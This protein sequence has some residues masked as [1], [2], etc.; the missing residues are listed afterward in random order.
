MNFRPLLVDIVKTSLS[1]MFEY[2]EKKLNTRDILMPKFAMN[3]Q[4]EVIVRLTVNTDG[5][6]VCKTPTTSAW[7]L[8][9]AIADLPPKPR[10]LFKNLVLG[11]LFVGSGYPDFDVFLSIYKTSCLFR[12]SSLS[13]KKN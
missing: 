6:A 13:M 11:A 2:A 1:E 12:R 10:Q 3:D 7:P 8:F 9:F 4:R 5:A